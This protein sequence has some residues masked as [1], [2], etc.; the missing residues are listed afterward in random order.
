MNLSTTFAS[1]RKTVA[2]FSL[3]T[4]VAGMLA[5]GVASA[6]TTH[7][8]TDV[9][10]DAWFSSFVNGLAADGVL[11]TTKDMYRPS[12]LVNRAEMA[13]FALAVSGLATEKAVSAPFKD[14][15]MGQWYTDAV[16]T[17]AKNN[18]VS[19]D[20]L[21][22]VPTGYFRPTANLNRAEATKMLVNAAQLAEDLKGA[23]HFGDV[24]SADWF[25]NFVETAFNSGV[26]SGYP[27]GTF[28][29]AKNIN[30]AEAAKMVYLSMHG[31]V[32]GFT[33]DS[34]AAASATQVELI[35]SANVD[36]TSSA[37]AANY[38]VTD[39]SGA[40]LAVSA[41]TFVSNDTVHL[42]TAT[43]NSGSTYY[44][45]AK[46]VKSA[47]GSNLSTNDKVSFL[48]YGADVSGGALS[49]ALS[50][51]T[52]VSGSVP[53]GASGVVFT[54]WDVK[55]GAAAAV[56]KSLR[57]HRVGPGSETN[58]SNVYLYRADSRLT[59]GRS[60]N[61]ETQMVEFNNVNQTVAAGENAKFCLV[62]D[63]AA[64]VSGGVHAFEV[65]AA[66]DVMTNS[67]DM[68]G[69]FPL[70]GADQLITSAVVGSAV[71]AK[72][73]SL[74]DITVGSIGS[75]IAQLQI[76]A[77]STEDV[78]LQRIALYV[79]GRVATT[80][81]QNL[82]LYALG[83]ATPV[84]TTA[85]VASNGLATF[86][87]A[88]P[89]KIGRGQN[90]IFYAT[91]D[92]SGARNGDDIKVYLDQPT[93]VFVVG[94]TYGYGVNVTNPTYNGGDDA[95]SYAL[96]KGSKFVVGFTGPNAGDVSVNQKQVRCLDMTLTNA[97]GLDVQI[98]DWQVK[99]ETTLGDGLLSAPPAGNFTLVKLVKLNDDGSIAGTL[100]GSKELSTSGS[101]T[102][103]TLTLP[104]TATIASGTS[105][106]TSVVFDTANN[107]LMSGGTIRCSLLPVTGTDM[108]KDTNNDALG[109][110]NITPASTISG[111]IMSLIASALTVSKNST[112]SAGSE[113][114]KGAMATLLAFQVRTAS[115]LDETIKTVVVKADNTTTL[116]PALAPGAVTLVAGAVT[117]IPAVGTFGAGYLT[118]P[119][120]TVNCTVGGPFTTA[121]VI[122]ATISGG[123]VVTPMTITNPGAS[124]I[125]C[126]AANITIAAPTGTTTNVKDLVDPVGLYDSTGKLVSDLKS[127]GTGATAAT[128]T[129]NNL[130]INVPKN[131][132]ATFYVKGTTSNSLTLPYAV[133]TY[134][135]ADMLALDNNQ[136]S[137]TGDITAVDT[138]GEGL[139][140][141]IG[142]TA[143]ISIVASAKN[144]PQ[145]YI[146]GD[147]K[148]AYQ[149]S[150]GTTKG[151][152][153]LQ[154]LDV[155]FN[156]ASAA[157][158]SSVDIY[159]SDTSGLCTTKITSSSVGP[160]VT[161]GIPT[162]SVKGLN[163]PLASTNKYICVYVN[164]NPLVKKSSEVGSPQS[165]DEITITA[166]NLTKVLTSDGSLITPMPTINPVP[167]GTHR[168]FRA[169]PS[170]TLDNTLLPSKS[171]TSG[172]NTVMAMKLS[173]VAQSGASVQRLNRLIVSY[174]VG[175]QDP[176]ACVLKVNG[177]AQTTVSTTIIP[178]AGVVPGTIDFDTITT[179]GV[180]NGDTLTVDCTFG[181]VAAN[182]S[183]TAQLLPIA[184]GLSWD[185]ESILGT[186]VL[187]TA[188]NLI[189]S[190]LFRNTSA[191]TA[192]KLTGV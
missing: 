67:A 176:S 82:K 101:D 11:D 106:K 128:A 90:K 52:P 60:I 167:F 9:P 5:T 64:G 104:G 68:T 121:P 36:A 109:A 42:T 191:L 13:K 89:Y 141:N 118:A 144:D 98:K 19:G 147:S 164:A 79:R 25:Y 16:Y 45:V 149:F 152:A 24:K 73:G 103:Q 110:A 26:V 173:N 41:A 28:G 70:R 159:S 122:T 56:V 71:V 125:N 135:A 102:T 107:A 100:L 166:V 97:A 163:L 86:A 181:A 6:A 78:N 34:A 17:L 75:R 43:Q 61:S 188:T 96:I 51:Q 133:T 65:L 32:K 44:V 94:T 108:V 161:G 15:A 39:S 81:V 154:D 62:A 29:P 131:S 83:D 156:A 27:D 120:V 30:R 10:A 179:G 72:N 112:P 113:Y 69:S 33:L 171:L 123:A 182:Q 186:N 165:G 105:M 74:D 7:V 84:A 20:K 185:D 37:V 190:I 115:T 88:T 99:L 132:N 174:A 1:L 2:G 138:V 59:T 134:L 187:F 77:G 66:G 18:I 76:T 35:F 38:T 137:I 57:V 48:G 31:V 183:F 23:P 158:V 130:N 155:V 47:A 175:S 160:V 157:S 87:L 92:I 148:S 58:F 180:S 85:T 116:T 21:N 95:Y 40:A 139:S 46:N 8:F 4:L 3:V 80:A 111:N 119:V 140:A 114:S 14:V 93:D 49:I 146:G 192:S 184:A 50:T 124:T 170:L 12:D 177:V 117:A 150:V 162:A 55:A 63:L 53:S 142:V 153:T 127:F 151:T 91:A 169:Y 129:F 136:Q 126:T 143:G 168:L 189:T 54:C 22:G 178:D 172:N 145:L